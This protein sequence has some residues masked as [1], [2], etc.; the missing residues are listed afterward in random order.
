M[1]ERRLRRLRLRL[2][3]CRRVLGLLDQLSLFL[4]CFVFFYFIS[5]YLFFFL[6]RHFL[7]RLPKRGRGQ[8]LVKFLLYSFFFF[9]VNLYQILFGVCKFLSLLGEHAILLLID[10]LLSK[11]ICVR[12]LIFFFFFENRCV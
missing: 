6:V 9:C 5:I 4:V 3:R 8:G 11:C 1:S 10:I 12:E 7:L 2:R